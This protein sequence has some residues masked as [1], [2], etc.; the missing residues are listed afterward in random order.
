MTPHAK[1]AFF[2]SFTSLALSFLSGT[3]T[4]LAYVT[5][6]FTRTGSSLTE[7]NSSLLVSITQIIANL[8]MLNIVERFNRRV[9]LLFVFISAN[10]YCNKKTFFLQTLYIWSSVLTTASYIMFGVY[11]LFWFKNPALEWMPPFCFACIVYFSCMG[12]LPIP[13]IITTEIFPKKAN[14]KFFVD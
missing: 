7:K 1:R 13:Y 4:I 5:D 9:F 3:L 12:L 11:C 6:I 2:I 14:Y 10:L 8:V